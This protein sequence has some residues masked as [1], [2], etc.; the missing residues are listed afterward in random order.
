[1][2]NKLEKRYGLTTAIAMVVG[3]VIGSGVF[4]KAEKVLNV[5]GGDLK[6]GILAWIIGGTIM[7]VCAYVFSLMATKYEF[8]NGIVDYAEQTVG[9]TYAYNIGWFMATMYYPA[10][11]SVLAWV[12]ARYFCVILGF[13]ILGSEALTL[14]GFF[15]VSSF[16][17]NSLSP[18]LAGNFQVS[19]TII[20]L[21]PL[22][23][24]A[25]VGTVV[26][27]S[28]GMTVT[29]FTTVVTEVDNPLK[30]LFTGVVAT[31]FAYEGWIIA[32]T[33]NAELKDAKTNLPKALV[34]GALI[35]VSTYILYY[36]G[37]AGGIENSIL[38]TAGEKGPLQAFKTVFGDIGSLLL[39]FFV[40]ISCLGTLNG[41]MMGA[42]R[43]IY[44]LSVRGMG[45]KPNLFK[46]V[47]PVSNI[48]NN[49]AVIGLLLCS[50][51]LVYFFGA[52]LVPVSWFG[53]FTFDS[54]ELVIVTVYALYLPIFYNFIKKSS[55]LNTFNRYVMP[56][57]A[58]I[59][60]I[61]M[62]I[63]CIYAHTNEVFYYLIL[64]SL[65]MI[66][67]NFFNSKNMNE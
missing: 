43:G 9:K 39:Y 11:T 1:M 30:A 27:L 47:D 24:M 14:A 51:W 66:L 35:T 58:I 38:M 29:N 65:I 19:T 2:N 59:C 21:I 4:F 42:T 32:T 31:A 8:V 44:S 17:M 20:K 22:V 64:F 10:I 41:L 67:G 18:K 28:N 5:T 33:I 3:I 46:Q 16:V 7:I 34:L 12:S 55:E 25:L 37:L 36:I 48:P 50:L 53:P 49:S 23:L 13:D 57:A 52:N 60:S 40:V 6:L 54:S 56:I 45:V 26:G 62:V 15:L 61:F 63:A